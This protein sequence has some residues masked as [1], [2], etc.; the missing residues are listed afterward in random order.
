LASQ[1]QTIAPQ[2]KIWGTRIA[3]E[4]RDRIERLAKASHDTHLS[5]SFFFG[6]ADPREGTQSITE[7]RSASLIGINFATTVSGGDGHGTEIKRCR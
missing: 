6:G 4:Q 2:T 5:V 3:K 1:I 7:V